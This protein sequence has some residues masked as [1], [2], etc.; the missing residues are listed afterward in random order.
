MVNI[1]YAEGVLSDGRPYRL[2]FW[3]EDQITNLTIFVS[4]L[5]IEDYVPQKVIDYLEAE[6]IF[7]R[8]RDDIYG[9]VL[10]HKEP[11]GNEFW[12][13]NLVVGDEDNTYLDFV[14]IKK[15]DW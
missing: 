11:N 10:S 15:W 14:P 2:E 1:G 8:R 12:S 9:S 6:R 7:R 3:A 5:G 4:A 13:A